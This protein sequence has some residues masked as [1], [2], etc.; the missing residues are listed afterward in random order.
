[1]NKLLFFLFSFQSLND[2][3]S[4]MEGVCL[5]IKLYINVL[6]V[7]P[8]EPKISPGLT[9]P[10]ETDN[11]I[12]SNNSTFACPL[13]QS[14]IRPPLTSARC[15][16]GSWKCLTQPHRSTAAPCYG[17]LLKAHYSQMPFLPLDYP[18]GLKSQNVS[19]TQRGTSFSGFIG[20]SNKKARATS[21]PVPYHTGP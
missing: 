20:F 21:T 19:S 6:G 4:C 10:L 13:F 1:M 7:G 15:S 16:W 18:Q 17:F 12:S 9:Q 14:A 2:P 11:Y 8:K 3:I 5:L